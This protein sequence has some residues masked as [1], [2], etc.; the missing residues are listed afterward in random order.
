MGLDVI[1]VGVGVGVGAGVGV[2]VNGDRCPVQ[3]RKIYDISKGSC[4][5]PSKMSVI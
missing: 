3:S 1:S 4:G 5:C 2:A